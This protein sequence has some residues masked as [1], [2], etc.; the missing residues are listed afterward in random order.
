MTLSKRR[1]GPCHTLP[2]AA[3][4]PDW[5]HASLNTLR[6]LRRYGTRDPSRRMHKPLHTAARAIL[7]SPTSARIS[8]SFPTRGEVSMR[9][10]KREAKLFCG[11]WRFTMALC[12]F[13][14][15]AR[16]VRAVPTYEATLSPWPYDGT[17]RSSAST[18]A[19]RSTALLSMALRYEHVTDSILCVDR[20]ASLHYSTSKYAFGFHHG[21]RRFEAAVR[22]LGAR[23]RT[24]DGTS[25]AILNERVFNTKAT[26]SPWRFDQRRLVGTGFSTMARG[27]SILNTESTVSYVRSMN[28]NKS[29][30]DR[31]MS[32]PWKHEFT[33]ALRNVG[34]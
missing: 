29:N 18:M 1:H 12:G 25:C 9:E 24:Y 26:L 34:T 8:P 10:A 16:T 21:V 23:D 2:T 28:N 32:S 31:S 11:V 20:H 6:S 4:Q 27:A 22:S 15:A 19:L 30:N 17:G 33:M 13:E 3:T 14:T 5:L 7:H